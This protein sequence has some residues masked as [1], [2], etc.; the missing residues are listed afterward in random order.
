MGSGCYQIYNSMFDIFLQA[1]FYKT[2][3]TLNSHELSVSLEN[4][5]EAMK[6]VLKN[7]RNKKSNII[8]LDYPSDLLY[9]DLPS[10]FK[11]SDISP[12]V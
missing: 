8:G 11:L 3:Y 4:F 12:W 10:F 1:G 5:S 6:F 2:F 7:R 9:R